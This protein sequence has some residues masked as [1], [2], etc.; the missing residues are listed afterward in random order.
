MPEA[1]AGGKDTKQPGMSAER[2]GMKGYFILICH[3]GRKKLERDETSE[4]VN[5]PMLWLW[6]NNQR[7]QRNCGRF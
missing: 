1:P 3:P 2:T 5:T 6:K 4:T 7:V